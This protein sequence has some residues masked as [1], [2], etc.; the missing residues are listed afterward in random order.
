MRVHILAK[1]SKEKKKHS[2][3]QLLRR[4]IWDIRMCRSLAVRDVDQ[5]G[6]MLVNLCRP[7]RL[8]W[9]YRDAENIS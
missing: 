5:R 7:R 1:R 8:W 6:V 9:A 2:M 3:A 4:T